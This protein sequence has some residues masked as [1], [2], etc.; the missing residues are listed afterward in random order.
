MHQPENRPGTTGPPCFTAEES[1]MLITILDQIDRQMKTFLET[2]FFLSSCVFTFDGGSGKD[3]LFR[4][5]YRKVCELS[6]RKASRFE[7]GG[8]E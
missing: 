1:R 3:E 2:S 8:E 4:G 5:I 7:E 6:H